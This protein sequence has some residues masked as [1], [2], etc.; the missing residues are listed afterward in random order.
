MQKW[1][2]KPFS[3]SVVKNEIKIRETINREKGRSEGNDR[4]RGDTWRF[5]HRVSQQWGEKKKV[6]KKRSWIG[7][8]PKGVEAKGTAKRRGNVAGAG[9]RAT[10]ASRGVGRGWL[11]LVGADRSIWR[12]GRVWQ[13]HTKGSFGRTDRWMDGWCEGYRYS[14][15]VST[16]ILS[17]LCDLELFPPLR[18]KSG[19]VADHLLPCR[20]S[21]AVPPRTDGEN[22][23]SY[24]RRRFERV[25]QILRPEETRSCLLR[26]DFHFHVC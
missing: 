26:C 16:A 23:I 18:R 3:Q 24:K 11:G 19:S 15:S 14:G 4:F 17:R 10:L 22:R 5:F 20:V 12:Q 2:S 6:G 21:H 8:W 9:Y 7:E 1:T 25:R 13:W